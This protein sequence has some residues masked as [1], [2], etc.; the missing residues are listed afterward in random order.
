MPEIPEE[1]QRVREHQVEAIVY[2]HLSNLSSLSNFF[3]AEAY[4]CATLLSVISARIHVDRN[5][6][7]V[8]GDPLAF[9]ETDI[10]VIA[11]IDRAAGGPTRVGLLIEIKVDARQTEDQGLRYRARA[12]HRQ[13]AGSWDDFRCVLVAPLR[14]LESAYPLNDSEAAGWNKLIAL[15]DISR[16]LKRTNTG[17]NDSRLIDEAVLPS[18]SWNK[19]IPSAARFWQDRSRMQRALY[20]DVPIFINRQQG[21]GINVW[22]SFYENQLASNRNDPR[23][24][25]VQIVHSGKS[26]VALFIK[27]VKYV[28][29]E[30]AVRPLLTTTIRIG[31]P[32]TTWQSV[33]I[34]VPEVDPMGT[35]EGQL[36]A[37]EGV[38]KAARELYGFFLE[39]EAVLMSVR[40]FK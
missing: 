10:E 20:P 27:K 35:V 22:P 5:H 9:G 26:H 12:L 39:N 29:F 23:R 19:P 15:E 25:R 28:E 24:K 7:K 40:T 38:L 11:K 34:A 4:P 18:N 13:T 8:S 6:V 2:K 36:A 37:L 31:A 33:R 14:Y 32:G 30:T 21:A 3:F 1:Y 16:V 17:T